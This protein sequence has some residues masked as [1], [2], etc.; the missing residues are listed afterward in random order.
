MT[1]KKTYRNP[2]FLDLR[3]LLERWAERFMADREARQR[4][5]EVTIATAA[6][7][8]ALLD[9]GPIEEALFGLMHRLAR[10]GATKRP[11]PS[12]VARPGL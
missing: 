4:L 6:G 12:P 1:L 2:E 5:V 7:N 11:L 9:D 3:P 8:P 10:E